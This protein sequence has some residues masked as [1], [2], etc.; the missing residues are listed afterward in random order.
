MGELCIA[1][2]DAFLQCLRWQ[3]KCRLYYCRNG[4]QEWTSARFDMSKLLVLYKVG[5]S[6]ARYVEHGYRLTFL[7]KEHGKPCLVLLV[8]FRHGSGW[9]ESSRVLR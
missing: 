3:L 8:W 9:G 7:I 5:L 1:V 2:V 4:D 6:Q